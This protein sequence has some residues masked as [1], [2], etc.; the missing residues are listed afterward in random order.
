MKIIGPGGDIVTGQDG[1]RSGPFAAMPSEPARTEGS[2]CPGLW[3]CA[4]PGTPC[5]S[6]SA[7]AGSAFFGVTSCAAWRCRP[8]LSGVTIIFDSDEPDRG[9]PGRRVTEN[10]GSRCCPQT[11]TGENRSRHVP[12]TGDATVRT[13]DLATEEVDGGTPSQALV[14]SVPAAAR[15]LRSHL[16]G[17]RQANGVQAV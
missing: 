6:S 11:G 5:A 13:H 17:P 12:Q 14:S 16:V 9:R 2:S 8:P 10:G 3:P 1:V 15:A 7:M 4:S